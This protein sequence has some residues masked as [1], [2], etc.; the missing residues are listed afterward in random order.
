[1]Y[2]S[3]IIDFAP[4][5]TTY[6]TVILVAH[7]RLKRSYEYFIMSITRNKGCGVALLNNLRH[8]PCLGII[9]VIFCKNFCQVLLW[10]FARW[11][12]SSSYNM[13][14]KKLTRADWHNVL[15]CVSLVLSL[16]NYIMR[17]NTLKFPCMYYE[18]VRQSR[19]WS[20]ASNRAYLHIWY[21]HIYLEPICTWPPSCTSRRD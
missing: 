14:I 4:N 20:R 6:V 19:A 16:I 7:N 13:P 3:N 21:M 17:I 10:Q 11:H 2:T 8:F 15:G 12:T 5:A 18:Y 9:F 1:M